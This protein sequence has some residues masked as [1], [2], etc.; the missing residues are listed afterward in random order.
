MHFSTDVNFSVRYGKSIGTKSCDLYNLKQK[1]N[2]LD[3][4]KKRELF[5][6]SVHDIISNDILLCIWLYYTDYQQFLAEF[7]NYILTIDYDELDLIINSTI[8]LQNVMDNFWLESNDNTLKT[9]YD[10]ILAKKNYIERVIK[11]GFKYTEKEEYDGFPLLLKNVDYKFRNESLY[12]QYFNFTQNLKYAHIDDILQMRT[13][14]EWK[15]LYSIRYIYKNVVN[16]LD[17]KY[18]DNKYLD[19]KYLN[20]KKIELYKKKQ[21]LESYLMLYQDTVESLEWYNPYSSKP[22]ENLEYFPRETSKPT[23]KYA[24]STYYDLENMAQQTFDDMDNNMIEIRR[25]NNIKCENEFTKLSKNIK[26]MIE[27]R[28]KK[29]T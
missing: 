7:K 29:Y 17:N 27:E 8:H 14:E 28:N 16:E 20:N 5:S 21:F 12:T 4:T 13:E 18:L 22:I 15:I 3:D 11:N 10:P 19:N 26:N 2:K 6:D 25:Q 9:N 24:Y 1:L 23:H